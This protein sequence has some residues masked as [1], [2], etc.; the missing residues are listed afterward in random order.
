MSK[1]QVQDLLKEN[2]NLK[3]QVNTLSSQIADLNE[4]TV[5]SSMNEMKERYDKMIATTVCINKFLNL[6]FHYT[7]YF[8]LAKT[9]DNVS[10]IIQDDVINLMHFL[11]YYKPENNVSFSEETK[12]NRLA[13]DLKNISNRLLMVSQLVNRDEDEWSDTECEDH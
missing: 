10:S 8:N 3:L 4:N 2:A 5:I 1:K 9:V 13:N 7:R 6:K 12:K 11:D